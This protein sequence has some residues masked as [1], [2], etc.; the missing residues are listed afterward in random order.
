L[1]LYITFS[2]GISIALYEKAWVG[3]WPE[4]VKKEVEKQVRFGGTT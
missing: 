2:K 4:E 1:W 3:V